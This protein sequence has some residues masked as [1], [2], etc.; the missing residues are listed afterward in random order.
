MGRGKEITRLGEDTRAKAM[1]LRGSLGGTDTPRQPHGGRRGRG[2]LVL[3]QQPG[4]PLA[5]HGGRKQSAGS[6]DP[7]QRRHGGGRA[8][9]L[10]SQHRLSK[11]E[12]VPERA[13]GYCQ[14]LRVNPHPLGKLRHKRPLRSHSIRTT[15][16]QCPCEGTRVCTCHGREG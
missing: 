9:G 14:A 16:L 6:L 5:P 7:D 15:T 1:Q 8:T 12:P 4:N 2:G 11:T 10:R 13:G 3:S